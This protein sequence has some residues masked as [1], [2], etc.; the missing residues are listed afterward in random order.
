MDL[1]RLNLKRFTTIKNQI[2]VLPTGEYRCLLQ[3]SDVQESKNGEEIL[4]LH[5]IIQSG[6]YIN[7]LYYSYFNLS[8]PM[9][10]KVL[11]IIIKNM[12]MD[13]NAIEDTSE[14]YGSECILRVKLVKHAIHG[15]SNLIERY[16]PVTAN[17]D[18]DIPYELIV[19]DLLCRAPAVYEHEADEKVCDMTVVQNCQ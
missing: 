9:S 19:D 5:W 16:L 6:K 11:F 1:K 3:D 18:D 12:G 10:L 17:L 7:C 15:V 14:L 2:E 8:K 13:P 4:R